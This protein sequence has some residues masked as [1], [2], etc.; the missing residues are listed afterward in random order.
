MSGTMAVCEAVS[1]PP[2]P[3]PPPV[4]ASEVNSPRREGGSMVHYL[5]HSARPRAII[6]PPRGL[7]KLLL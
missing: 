6:L 2:A 7:Q 3:A 4:V 5:A 1:D